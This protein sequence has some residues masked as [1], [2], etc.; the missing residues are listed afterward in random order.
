MKTKIILDNGTFEIDLYQED[1]KVGYVQ[2][3]KVSSNYLSIEH[4]IVYE[5][6]QGKGYA[7]ILIEEVV[8]FA[9]VNNFK[10][11]PICSYAVKFFDKNKE[12]YDYLLK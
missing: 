1:T 11:I 12:E 8:H 6:Y 5:Q 10:I 2:G 7:K 9:K 4:T 3:K